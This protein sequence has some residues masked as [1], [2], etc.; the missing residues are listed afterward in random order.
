MEWFTLSPEEWAAVRLSLKVALV[1]TFVSLPFG[2]ATAM[3]LV[4]GR[5]WGRSLLDGLVMMPLILPPVVTGYLL[6]ICSGG[7]DPSVRFSNNI[8]GSCFRFA[9]RAQ[10][11]P[12]GSW[13]SP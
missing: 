12:A 13:H 2:I 6:L 9:G 8:A 1:A 4:R 11:W 10:L 7:A 5:F 3:L